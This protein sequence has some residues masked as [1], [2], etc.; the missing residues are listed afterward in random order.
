[1]RKIMISVGEA[2]GD[3]HGASLAKAL[4]QL[5]PDIAVFG[6]GGQA[7]RDAGVDIVY[8]I[9]DINV[10]GFVE[11]IKNLPRLFRLKDSLAALMAAEKPDVLVVIDYPD[12]NMRL[13]K[14]AKKQG[15]SVVYY[16]SPQVWIWRKG[17]AKDIAAMTEQV[18]A[19]FPFEAEVYREAGARV[20][21]VGH[22][23]LDIV[24]PAW[25]K[26]TAYRYFGADP[27]RPVVLLMPGSR[28]QE[29][30]QLLDIMLSAA[31]EI[32]RTMP[33]CQFFLPVATTISREILQNKLEKY[34]LPVQITTGNTY[35]LMHIANLAIAASGTATLETALMRVPTIVVYKTS[36]IT[37]FIGR[38][39]IK[40][41]YVSLPNIIAGRQIVPE[42]L[43]EA[44]NAGQ[45][46]G[47]A[48][49][50]LSDWDIYSHTIEDLIAMRQTLGS[51]GAV[52]RTAELVLEVA[53]QQ[54]GGKE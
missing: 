14:A 16:I 26:E 37:Y 51:G 30:D 34:S 24:K 36:P 35:E 15:I 6:M 32:R 21:F 49:R 52:Q 18:A 45:V 1:M 23:L 41:P 22:P 39:L 25:D 27:E 20:T 11:V 3:L 2:S 10:M 29:V 44:A 38:Q 13:A 31:E 46:A 53:A 48:L 4:K 7:M 5:A 54:A 9:A 47:E 42:L 28:K 17:R 50:I 8:D 40:I 43:Q 19:I 33:A 12:F